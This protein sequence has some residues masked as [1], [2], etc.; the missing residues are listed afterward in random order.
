MK[1]HEDTIMFSEIQSATALNIYQTNKR[2][3][4]DADLPLE[5]CIGSAFDGAATMSGHLNGVAALLKK[6][7]PESV[8]THCWS[9]KLSLSVLGEN[10]PA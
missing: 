1:T 4:A 8:T 9:H 2:M 7:V 3:L 6:D 5:S 10:T